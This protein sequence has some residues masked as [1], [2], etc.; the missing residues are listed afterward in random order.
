MIKNLGTQIELQMK[1]NKIIRIAL[2]DDDPDEE[3]FF[4]I[5]LDFMEIDYEFKFFIN[6]FN[7][8]S[9][10]EKENAIL[11]DIVFVD[12]KMPQISG[13]EMVRQL[14]TN[15][16]FDSIQAII[17]TAHIGDK[18]KEIMG[19]MGIFDFFIK[20]TE[21]ADLTSMLKGIIKDRMQ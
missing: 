7:F 12:M 10:I 11:P 4:Q 16:A 6:A 9:A 20:P 2:V 17:Y 3:A 21:F 13:Q 8:I 18:E 5:A 14:R 1:N 15:K 19:A